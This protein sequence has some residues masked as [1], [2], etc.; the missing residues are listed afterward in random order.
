M[1]RS[2]WIAATGM[3]G[4]A[5]LTENIANNLANVNTTSYKKGQVHFQDLFYQTITQR[6]A[7]GTTNEVPVGI[8]LG[9]GSRVSGITKDFGVG[10]LRETSNELNLAIAGD[11]FF[12]VTLPDGT[13]AY[14]RDGRFHRN[15][16]GNLVTEN[17]YQLT[18]GIN[19]Q[20][21]ATNV[22]ITPDGAVN[23]TVN[24]TT[25]TT[26]NIQVARFPNNEGLQP[27]GDNLYIVTNA[28]GQA[29]KG[30]PD[31]NGRG[32]LR[33]GFL[34]ASNVDVVKEMVTMIS[35]QR[36]YEVISKS[37]KTSDEMLRTATNIK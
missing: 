30:T 16:E 13:L 19:I 4:Q 34:E 2:L 17:G 27:I 9:T 29:T 7:E 25:T 37:I 14:T 24:N 31:Q 33:Q 5:T 21:D 10:T 15:S 12:E 20:A 22:T 28:S 8:T 36:A 32:R 23:V 26:G 35:A 18:D 3:E 6:G 1:D 11:G